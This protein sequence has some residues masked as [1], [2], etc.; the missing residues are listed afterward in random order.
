[1]SDGRR[2]RLKRVL[3][4]LV[5]A[6][7]VSFFMQR[8][9]ANAGRMPHVAWNVTTGAIGVVSTLLAMLA[10]VLSGVIWQVLLRDQAIRVPWRRVVSLYLVAQFGKYLP[11]NVGQYVGRV[12]LGKDIG[13][14]VPVTLATMVTEALWGIGTALGLSALSL[15]LFLGSRF[16][17]LPSWASATG[18]A[19]CFVGLL[20]APWLGISLAKRLFPNLAIRL[21]GTHG[22][23]PPGWQAALLVSLLYVACSLCMGLI[24]QWQ[25]HYLFGEA[26]AP[27][28]LLSGFFAFAWL[29]GYLL[30]GAPA[31]IGV[32]ESMMVL[33]FAPTFGEGTALALGVTLRLATTL[34][35]ALAFLIGTGWRLSMARKE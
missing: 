3:G 19:L 35:D 17:A 1:M 29:A 27:L 7:A 28:L 20:V 12:L 33:L 8:V 14:P 6:V 9:F 15:Y 22:I 11:G 25:S 4:W 5:A 23:S 18:L 10:I 32:R 16:S 26:P 34:A 21:F 2:F 24:L 30:P 13:I 31:G